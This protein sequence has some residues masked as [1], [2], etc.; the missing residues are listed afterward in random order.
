MN[1]GAYPTIKI[2][3][4][5]R[6]EPH[7]QCDR[8]RH[9]FRRRRS[10]QLEQYRDQH[11][12]DSSCGPQISLI[13]SP[14]PSTLGQL[15]TLTATINSAATG[16]VTFYDGVN[17]LGSAALSGGQATWTTRLLPSGTNNLT[18]EY[19]GNSTYGF[20]TSPVHVQI[21]NAS[22]DNALTPATS[23]KVDL[24]PRALVTADFNRDG[25][26]DLAT[27]NYSYPNTSGSINVLLGNGNGTFQAAVSYPGCLRTRPRRRLPIST[28]MERRIWRSAGYVL[29]SMLALWATEDT[30]AFRRCHRDLAPR[31]FGRLAVAGRQSR[32]NPRI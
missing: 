14:N 17:I 9:R 22:L 28:K 15:V 18:V 30:A 3:C 29:A 13:S 25:I 5:H 20:S 23:Y 19:G 32:R 21:V 2:T 10:K 24:A 12:L 31:A 8:H 4:E 26:L 1:V 7:R 27:V 16:E 11:R 6:G